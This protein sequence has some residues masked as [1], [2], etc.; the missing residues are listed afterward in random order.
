MYLFCCAVLQANARLLAYD[1][2]YGKV[3]T[4]WGNSGTGTGP[5]NSPNAL[6]PNLGLL[7]VPVGSGGHGLA[8]SDL[9]GLHVSLWRELLRVGRA[10]RP[11][12]GAGSK[13]GDVL[14]RFFNTNWILY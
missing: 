8:L 2:N 1:E 14:I 5:P 9:T 10:V 4:T 12:G 3:C 13:F 7:L 11:H 6:Q